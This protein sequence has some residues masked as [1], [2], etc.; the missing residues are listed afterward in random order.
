VEKAHVL[1]VDEKSQKS[2]K[3]Q[4]SQ[5]SQKPQTQALNRTAQMLRI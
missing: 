2:Q 1:S 4:K 5:K 3:R